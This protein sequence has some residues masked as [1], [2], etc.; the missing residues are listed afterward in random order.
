M[1]LVFETDSM[2]EVERLL[3]VVGAEKLI[4]QFKIRDASVNSERDGVLKVIPRNPEVDPFAFFGSWEG[5]NIDGKT[6]R[7]QAWKRN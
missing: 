6:L 3:K 2:E 7:E 1:T 4:S 5:R